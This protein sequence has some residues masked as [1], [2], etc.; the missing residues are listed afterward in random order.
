MKIAVEQDVRE[1]YLICFESLLVSKK[2]KRSSSSD[3]QVEAE[4]R[5]RNTC[6]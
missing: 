3:R 4:S 6:R 1:T 5:D 2:Q